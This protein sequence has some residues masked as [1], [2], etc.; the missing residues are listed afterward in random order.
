MDHVIYTAMSGAQQALEAQAVISNNI[1]N[2][3]TT[4]FREQ[5]LSFRSVPVE[6]AGAYETRVSVAVATPGSDF[7]VGPVQYTGRPLDVAMLDNAWL[8]VTGSDGEEAYTRRG[9]L[10]ID[11][12]GLLTSAGHPVLGDGGPIQVPLGAKLF[13]GDDGTLSSL[14][15]GEGPD[16]IAQLGRL[17]LVDATD[18]SLVRT[19]EGLF[20][21]APDEFGGHLPL[22]ADENARVATGSLEGSN[23]SA[24]KSM[25]EM[26]ANA[27]LY[28][29]QMQVVQSAKE[30]DQ[31]ANSLLSLNG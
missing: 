3:A 23:V 31:Q 1:A 11:S 25:V 5:M 12:E 14:G 19:D 22:P 30:N 26:I 18:V 13:I 2:A 10:Q 9:D 16:S 7:S 21:Q 15:E 8:A 29:M 24:V 28:E 27:R 17:K 20:K 6:G 4:G